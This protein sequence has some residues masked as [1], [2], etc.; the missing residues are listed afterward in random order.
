MF[1]W[2][3]SAEIFSDLCWKCMPPKWACICFC[4]ASGGPTS[5]SLTF[6]THA[7]SVTVNHKSTWFLGI[8]KEDVCTSFTRRQGQ[9]RKVFSYFLV[10]HEF[11]FYHLLFPWRYWPFRVSLTCSGSTVPLDSPPG[12]WN[13]GS[14]YRVSSFS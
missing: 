11:Y 5:L 3:V 6:C 4:Q 8:I 14:E 13:P 9:S 1:I 7:G 2:L 10:L 12:C